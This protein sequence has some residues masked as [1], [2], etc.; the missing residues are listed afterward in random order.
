MERWHSFE[1]R[2]GDQVIASYYV[3]EVTTITEEV[4]DM[5]ENTG[6]DFQRI[7]KE[8]DVW[9]VSIFGQTFEVQGEASI[10]AFIEREIVAR[11]RGM[12]A[13]MKS[14]SFIQM[15]GNFV[16][17]KPKEGRPYWTTDF[18]NNENVDPDVP[19]SRR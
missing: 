4:F 7:D 6:F 17:C 19:W 9:E 5:A 16:E 11:L 8:N 1:I 14:K 18:G 13:V 15:D 2:A 3:E 12:V 10:P